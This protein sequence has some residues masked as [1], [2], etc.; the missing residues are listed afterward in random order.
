M[1]NPYTGCSTRAKTM[2]CWAKHSIHSV[3]HQTSKSDTMKCAWG[4]WS[5]LAIHW[6]KITKLQNCKTFNPIIM[7]KANKLC[8][9]CNVCN[10]L[11]CRDLLDVARD[12]HLMPERRPLLQTFKARPRC[13]TDI[14]GLVYAVGGLT[15]S[16]K[17]KG[18]LTISPVVID[19]R[20]N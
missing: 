9:M 10:D 3:P 11:C 4:M 7:K 20:K 12:Y 17:N 18:S 1:K 13:C 15:S 2:A 19:S 6:E 8:F 5:E 14:P 16:G